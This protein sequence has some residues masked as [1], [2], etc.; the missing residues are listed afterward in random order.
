MKT[1]ASEQ[2]K[3]IF[4]KLKFIK[5]E[6]TG[7]Y[8]SFV[9]QNPKTGRIVGIRQDSEYPKKICII[10]RK[11]SNIIIPNILYDATLIPMKEKNGYIAIEVNPV[12]FKA[13]VET[14]YVPKALYKIEVKFG[15]KTILFDPVDGK[16]D[17][18]RIVAGVREILEK[19]MDIKALQQVIDDFSE[20]AD[21]LMKYYKKD[22]IQFRQRRY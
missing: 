14:T 20:Q 22:G 1:N 6:Q 19:R 9:S 17:S 8:I 13:T 5:S 7:A 2:P 4:T 10:D 16:K 15:N 12:S 11:L 21:L 3:K 18:V